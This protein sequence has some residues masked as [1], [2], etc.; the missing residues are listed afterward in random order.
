MK[1][2]IGIIAVFIVLVIL[3][4]IV[5]QVIWGID[6]VRAE[7]ITKSITSLCVLAIGA[8]LLTLILAFFFRKEDRG[9]HQTTD[10]VAQRK[11]DNQK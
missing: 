11:L 10:G 3:A 6:V 1:K 2:V 5:L 8:F 9:Y 4:Y 7:T